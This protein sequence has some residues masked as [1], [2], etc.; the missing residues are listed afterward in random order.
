MLYDDILN[1]IVVYHIML[2]SYMTWYQVILHYVI[3]IIIF[4]WHPIDLIIILA[5]NIIQIPE[6]VFFQPHKYTKGKKNE[7]TLTRYFGGC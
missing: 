4:L 2:H 1:N 3:I 6:V 5:C 7:T